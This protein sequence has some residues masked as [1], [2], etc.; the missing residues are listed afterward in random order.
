MANGTSSFLAKKRA[1][2]T[3]PASGETT[4]RS[5]SSKLPEVAHQ[6]RAG[7]QVV[8]RD[9]EKS[10]NLRRVQIDQQRPVRAGRA[11]QVRH[12]LGRNRDARP[13]FA[14]LPCVAVVRHHHRNASGRC[15]LQRVDHDQQ[16]HQML[17]HGVACGLYQKHIHAANILQQLKVHLAIGEA[18]QLGLAQR[19]ADKLADLLAQCAIGRSAKNLEAL[20]FTQ[21]GRA[22][23]LRGRLCSIRRRLW[24]VRIDRRRMALAQAGICS[25]S[26]ACPEIGERTAVVFW[27]FTSKPSRLV[28]LGSSCC[29]TSYGALFLR[30]YF[31]LR[32]NQTRPFKLLLLNLYHSRPLRRAVQNSKIRPTSAACCCRQRTLS[33]SPDLAP[34]PVRPLFSL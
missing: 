29:F 17:V 1:R 18:L 11:Q 30:R 16:L 3:P 34:L 21:L 20:V 33:C 5:G 7:E 4:V 27:L 2:S 28:D 12:Q 25:G 24:R 19:H 22:L 9:I 32:N 26:S 15:A 13:V 8:H 14:V 31:A 6:H 23:P 10:L